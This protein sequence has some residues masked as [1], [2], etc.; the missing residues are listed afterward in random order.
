MRAVGKRLVV[1]MKVPLEKTKS[2]LYIPETA[3]SMLRNLG[4]IISV[5]G[6]C[7][8]DVKDGDHVLVRGAR[9]IPNLPYDVIEEA[10]V[11]CVVTDQDIKDIEE[12]KYQ[13]ETEA[14]E[15]AQ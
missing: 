14:M 11:I 9:S 4:R 6:G 12:G 10:D 13:A 1:Q 5:G 15:V 8:L 7:E 2:G 3:K